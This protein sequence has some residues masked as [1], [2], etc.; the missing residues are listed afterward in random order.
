MLSNGA[1]DR[2]REHRVRGVAD[3][4][5]AEVWLWG[6]RVGAAAEDRA[7]R[8]V[9]QYDPDF[10][11]DGWEI[12][13]VHLLRA[14]VGS[15]PVTFDELTRVEAFQGLPGV[16]ADA[17][18]DRFGNAII[19]KYFIDRGQVDAALSPVQRLLYVGARALGALEFRPA[20]RRQ[21]T[22]AELLPLQL[23]ALVTEAQAVIGGRTDIAL[24]EIMRIGA[25]A[26]GARAKA[27]VLW[28]RAAGTLRSD[29]A[30]PAPGEEHWLLKFDGTGER[31]APS[32]APQ[33]YNRIEAAYAALARDGGL[34]VA[35]TELL[36]DGGYTHRMVRRFD[37][38]RNQPG[39]SGA[40]LHLHSLG[41]MQHADYNAP[42]AYSYEGLLRTV[43][44][45]GLDYRVLTEA[46]RRAV[47][48][49]AFVNQDDHVKNIS[50]LMDR[51]AGWRLAPAYDLTFAR[52][53]GFTRN[54]Q[55]SVNGKVTDIQ[56]A[57]LLAL[58]ALVGLPRDGAREIDR[59][60]DARSR[61][62]AVA[63]SKGVPAKDIER[64]HAVFPALRGRK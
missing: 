48:N 43:L 57:D 26:G 61:W 49:V 30:P 64:V 13:P 20:V 29:F 58:G 40:R 51:E 31:G 32:D 11:R 1:T 12:S 54:H 2:A 27:V 22:K 60:L 50:F 63:E 52:G 14:T 39:S 38:V 21:V 44:S 35:E 45:L 56:H 42:G 17:L 55:M 46:F 7:G 41:G 53:A 18:P 59:I 15:A 28:N 62:T 4:V 16:L 33:P 24:P 34:H 6:R 10:V 25:S 36:E 19:T 37:R 3:S 47:F 8:V 9:F 23:S 5:G